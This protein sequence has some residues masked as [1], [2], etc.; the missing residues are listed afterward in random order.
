MVQR[1]NRPPP[2]GHGHG[3]AIVLCPSPP[4]GVVGLWYCPPSP[5]WCGGG[6][7]LRIYIYI[8][9]CVN[10]YIYMN[11]CIYVSLYVF[12]CIYIYTYIYVCVCMCM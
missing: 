5:L 12:M 1:S 9:V 7:I 10:I 4:C 8:S 6:V 2:P 3:S 11:I